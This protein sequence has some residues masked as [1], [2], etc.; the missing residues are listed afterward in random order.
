M[1][2]E[3]NTNEVSRSMR[4]SFQTKTFVQT[5]GTTIQFIIVQKTFDSRVI[6][7]TNAEITVVA[8]TESR[9]ITNADLMISYRRRF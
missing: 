3:T 8:E 5:M 4:I 7:G 6:V 2:L 9:L 1:T